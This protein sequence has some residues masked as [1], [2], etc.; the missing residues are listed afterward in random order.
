MS[1]MNDEA[2][3]QIDRVSHRGSGSRVVIA[4]KRQGCRPEEIVTRKTILE[5]HAN[6][7]YLETKATRG[8]KSR[9]NL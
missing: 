3:E 7:V 9:G 6:K 2:V 4:E 5:Q 8:K 1:K